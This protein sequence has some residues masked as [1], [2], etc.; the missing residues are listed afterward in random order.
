M[1]MYI[2]HVYAHPRYSGDTCTCIY[3]T[4]MAMLSVPEVFFTPQACDA[5]VYIMLRLH[6]RDIQTV[7]ATSFEL[8]F[9]V[10][11]CATDTCKVFSNLI[12]YSYY[13]SFA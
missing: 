6:V 12:A 3:N 10:G 8:L 2:V 13:T 1:D 5:E 7:V 4:Y 9:V 11:S